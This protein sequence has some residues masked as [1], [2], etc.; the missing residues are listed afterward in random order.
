MVPR[1]AILAAP[2]LVGVMADVYSLRAA[3]LVI[4]LAA[5]VVLVL[6]PALPASPV[7]R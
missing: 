4:P 1:V 3:L 7:R 6:A 2:A 5:V